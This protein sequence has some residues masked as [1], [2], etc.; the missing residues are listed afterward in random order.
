MV[1]D[2]KL[3]VEIRCGGVA[4]GTSAA[5]SLDLDPGSDELKPEFFTRHACVTLHTEEKRAVTFSH[6]TAVSHCTRF[7]RT[8]IK[9]SSPV[10]VSSSS[11]GD[12]NSTTFLYTCSSLPSPNTLKSLSKSSKTSSMHL[13]FFIAV[14]VL[15]FCR[16]FVRWGKLRMVVVVVVMWT[17]VTELL[18]LNLSCFITQQYSGTQV[19]AHLNAD[20]FSVTA[21][22]S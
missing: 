20:W 6:D 21:E 8:L 22:M 2:V 12:T 4:H 1:V 3:V 18:S 17:A 7:W 10:L 11:P 14:Q 13:L 9:E 19:L 16:S 5:E 15:C